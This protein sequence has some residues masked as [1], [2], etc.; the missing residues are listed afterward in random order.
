MASSYPNNYKAF[1][2]HQDVTDTVYAGDV[3]EI[4][5]EVSSLEVTLGKNPQVRPSTWDNGTSPYRWATVADR[6]NYLHSGWDHEVFTAQASSP[7]II[8]ARYP[9]YLSNSWASNEVTG[10]QDIHNM[11]NGNTGFN[12]KISGWYQLSADAYLNVGT[13]RTSLV[14]VAIMT[15]TPGNPGYIGFAQSALTGSYVSVSG[16][17]HLTGSDGVV[18]ADHHVIKLSVENPTTSTLNIGRRR[19]SGFLVQA[20]VPSIQKTTWGYP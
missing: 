4:Q 6:L 15:A 19:L 17:I 13:D 16:L 8:D 1:Q 11:W 10:N 14:H 12:I 7:W 9:G 2:K 20:D 18:G 5:D 3:N